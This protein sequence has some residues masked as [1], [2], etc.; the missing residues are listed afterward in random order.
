MTVQVGSG[1][2]IIGP[3]D[4]IRT[5]RGITW[6]IK[7]RETPDFSQCAIFVKTEGVWDID[8]TPLAQID[9]SMEF[10]AQDA[11]MMTWF[12]AKFLPKLNSWLAHKFPAVTVVPPTTELSPIV[13]ADM[14]I[15]SLLV[16]TMNGD[17]TLTAKEK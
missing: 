15:N 13:Q 6:G 10:L 11:D 5:D 9:S 8:Q 12:R 17:G 4:F 14:L 3:G 7:C 16:I 2:A 1:R